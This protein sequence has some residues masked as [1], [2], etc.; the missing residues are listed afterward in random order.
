MKHFF[1]NSA[2]TLLVGIA[3]TI[4]GGYGVTADA[5]NDDSSNRGQ[6]ASEELIDCVLP[7]KVKKMGGDMSY[8]TPQRQV[9]TTAEECEK[10]GG[11]V[12][13]GP[14]QAPSEK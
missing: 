10:S 4:L 6:T 9:K 11:K 5:T 3:L 7:G 13:A 1:A 12:S 14:K 8:M 2:Q